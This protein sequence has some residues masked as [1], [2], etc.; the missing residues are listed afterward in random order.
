MSRYS[1]PRPNRYKPRSFSS[2]ISKNLNRQKKEHNQRIEDELFTIRT[3]DAKNHKGELVKIRLDDRK[4]GITGT[5]IRANKDKIT[6][7]IQR[8]IEISGI[9]RM[10]NEEA[11]QKYTKEELKRLIET[12]KTRR[13][14][15][16]IVALGNIGTRDKQDK[17]NQE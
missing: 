17:D 7:C 1:P 8:E 12:E 5:I 6:L 9:T 10:I 15:N 13:F 11:K 2:E 16:N 14:H 3:E 4:A